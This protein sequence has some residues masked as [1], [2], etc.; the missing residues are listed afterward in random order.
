MLWL[1]AGEFGE[2]GRH[3]RNQVR[4]S[5]H[6]AWQLGIEREEKPT[7]EA[8]YSNWAEKWPLVSSQ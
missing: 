6:Q 1:A 7:F 3:A 2:E 5:L 4:M 8:L